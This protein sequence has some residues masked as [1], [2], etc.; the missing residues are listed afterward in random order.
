MKFLN[1]PSSSWAVHFFPRLNYELPEILL[2]KNK[3][4][5]KTVLI[6]THKREIKNKIFIFLLFFF[7]NQAES[8]QIAV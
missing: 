3:N 8:V 5:N 7:L 2:T 4:K 1:F 6:V